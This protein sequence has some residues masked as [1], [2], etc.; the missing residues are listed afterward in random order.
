MTQADGPWLS[1]PWCGG[2]VPL[3]HLVA[4]DEEPYAQVAVCQSCGRR[5]TILPPDDPWAGR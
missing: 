3:A 2:Q 5:V 4:S 1:C